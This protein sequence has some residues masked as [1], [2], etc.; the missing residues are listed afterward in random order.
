Y[1]VDILQC[2][3]AGLLFLFVLRIIIK[4]D[5]KYNKI[6]F[7]L[8]ILIFLVSPLVWK[9][10][11]GKFFIIPI[12][13][14][15]NKQYG[16][17]FPLFPWLGFL[18]SG[19]VTAKLYLNARTNNNEKKFIMNLTIVGLAFA[20]GGHF[21]LS[22]IFPENYRMIR[23][24]PVFDILRLGWVLFLLG[25]F[26]YYAEYRNTKRSFVL[27]VGRESLLVYWLHLE[28]IY[29]HFW[30]GQSLVSAVN[31][32]LNFIEAVMLVLIVATLM[33]LVAKIWGRFK[34]DY[35][36]PAAKLTFTIVSLCIIIFLIGF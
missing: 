19:T 12:A 30:K 9:I 36:E 29:R 17:L 4:S 15:F 28:I 5:D 27:D 25:M 23:P 22:G 11:W 18:F 32:K 7:A 21:L 20:L 16:S 10:D 26:W 3:A 2:I 6:V 8:A 35:R 34:K 14:Y 13:A 33:V 31:H 24:H 1:N